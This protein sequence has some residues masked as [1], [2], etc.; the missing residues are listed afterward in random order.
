[1]K[2]HQNLYYLP[3]KDEEFRNIKLIKLRTSRIL[4]FRGFYEVSNIGRVRSIS[5]DIQRGSKGIL[6]IEGKILQQQER[7]SCYT[8]SLTNGKDRI[9]NYS[10]ARLVASAFLHVPDNFENYVVQHKNADIFDNRVQNLKIVIRAEANK[11]NS[12]KTI[13]FKMLS[14]NKSIK[15]VAK[16]L[17]LTTKTVR[18]Y[19]SLLKK[20]NP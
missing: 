10:V 19:K 18:Q 12:K 16:E 8:V 14:Q 7:N 20:M 17:G 11:E 2:P 3:V 15:R 1:M 13:A 5:R 6:R 9:S 4:D